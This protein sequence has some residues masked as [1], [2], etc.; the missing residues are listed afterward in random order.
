[1]AEGSDLPA[2]LRVQLDQTVAGRNEEDAFIAA[3]VGPRY[4]LGQSTLVAITIPL[5]LIGRI[6]AIPMTYYQVIL[7]NAA[8]YAL[9]GLAVEPFL[10][11]RQKNELSS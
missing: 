5:S 3:T 9:I 4:N 6:R 2:G 8:T 10:R 1:L 11:H 7:M